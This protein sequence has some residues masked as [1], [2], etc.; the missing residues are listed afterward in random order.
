MIRLIILRNLAILLLIMCT[1]KICVAQSKKTSTKNLDY[2]ITSSGIEVGRIFVTV[3]N[4]D[5]VQIEEINHEMNLEHIGEDF[6]FFQRTQSEWLN[7]QLASFDHWLL[8]GDDR[9]HFGGKRDGAT[10]SISVFEGK[11]KGS[12]TSDTVPV[13]QTVSNADSIA[14]MISDQFFHEKLEGEE[15]IPSSYYDTTDLELSNHI[16]SL[17]PWEGVRNIRVFY[18]ESLERKKVKASYLGSEEV[19]VANRM[20]ACDA[21]SLVIGKELHTLWL[22][23]SADLGVV[24][25][26]E[27]SLEDGIEFTALL[28]N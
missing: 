26:K 27:V 7:G 22:T 23:R 17:A 3:S 2:L 28:Q 5:S 11:S 24:A 21:F 18:T 10:L 1:A 6:V 12:N 20:F 9:Y 16:M 15:D 14:S 19:K 8:L 25:I 4:K 13:L